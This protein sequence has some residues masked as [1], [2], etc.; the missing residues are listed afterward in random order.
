MLREFFWFK[1][2]PRKNLPFGEEKNVVNNLKI[3][4]ETR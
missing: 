4:D 2:S 1:L 3:F